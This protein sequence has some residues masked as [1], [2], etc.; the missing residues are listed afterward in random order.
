[1]GRKFNPQTAARALAR[2]LAV[3][4]LYRWQVNPCPWQD[5]VAEFGTEPD[6]ARA[7]Q[8]YFELLVRAALE[9]HSALDVELTPLMGREASGLDPVE[10]AVLLVAAL[11]LRSQPEVPFRVV[12]SEAVGIARRFGATDGHKFV[13]G[14]LDRAAR[15]WRPDER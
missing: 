14:V 5:L 8:S 7:D 4:A 9:Q 6:M 13:N 11:E 10:H 1:V 12:I 15:A 2:R 3:Q